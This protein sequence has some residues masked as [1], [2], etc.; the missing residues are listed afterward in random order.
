MNL[1]PLV[2]LSLLVIPYWPLHPNWQ[3][4]A[5]IAV[6]TYLEGFMAAIKYKNPIP[7]KGLDE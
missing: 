7:S 5:G 6:G 4:A 1:L 3:L 2:A